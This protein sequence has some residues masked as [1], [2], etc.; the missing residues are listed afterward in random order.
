[1]TAPPETLDLATLA[2]PDPPL[3]FSGDTPRLDID[4]AWVELATAFD[5]AGIVRAYGGAV[6]FPPAVEACIETSTA[7]SED[8]ILTPQALANRYFAAYAKTLALRYCGETGAEVAL[9]VDE[10]HGTETVRHFSFFGLGVPIFFP[11]PEALAPDEWLA[12]VADEGHGTGQAPEALQAGLLWLWYTLAYDLQEDVVFAMVAT[13]YFANQSPRR[14]PRRPRRL[15]N[16]TLNRVPTG[17]IG[18][19]YPKDKARKALAKYHRKHK[20]SKDVEYG[21]LSRDAYWTLVALVNKARDEGAI[22]DEHDIAKAQK[23]TIRDRD[24]AA[25]KAETILKN[26]G[27]VTIKNNGYYDLAASLDDTRGPDGKILRGTR[28]AIAR[29]LEEL[30]K[31]R[32]ITTKVLVTTT[33]KGA[34][35]KPREYSAEWTD[36]WVKLMDIADATGAV[37]ESVYIVHIAAFT[38]ISHS[39]IYLA[40]NAYA[41]TRAALEAIGCDRDRDEFHLLHMYLLHRGSGELGKVKRNR[42]TFAAP[43]TSEADCTV[44]VPVSR[45]LLWDELKLSAV[46]SKRGRAEAYQRERDAVAYCREIGILIDWHS[47]S[48]DLGATLTFTVRPPT[49]RFADPA[50]LLLAPAENA[51]GGTQ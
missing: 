27:R 50:Q 49:K 7:Q 21:S 12:T 35:K 15:K 29:G 13:E 8:R 48:D 20:L 17:V 38:S 30:V 14:T 2:I 9:S 11:S 40:K 39:W 18:S 43:G 23:V 47:P 26:L 6:T 3:T 33:G 1:M 19:W 10:H 36:A 25:G 46:A 22:T 16:S 24:W 45:K 31:T 42:E 41:E 5:R 28:D 4:A 44:Q 34:G 37:I 51:L 32:V